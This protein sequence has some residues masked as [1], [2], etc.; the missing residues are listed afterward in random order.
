VPCSDSEYESSQY[1]WTNDDSSDYFSADEDEPVD[2]NSEVRCNQSALDTEGELSRGTNVLNA[3]GVAVQPE[4]D[5]H[6]YRMDI[7]T[8]LF[9][10]QQI[11]VF[12]DK[13]GLNGKYQVGLFDGK[14]RMYTYQLQGRFK[15]QP[16]GP[17]VFQASALDHTAQLGMIS[18]SLS[19]TWLAFARSFCPDLKLNLKAKDGRPLGAALPV[20]PSWLGIIKTPRGETPPELGTRLP[21]YEECIKQNGC[22]VGNLS[23]VDLSATY[24]IEYYT[25]NADFLDWRL[26][27]IPVSAEYDFEQFC[28]SL[29]CSRSNRLNVLFS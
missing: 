17:I 29:C 15:R 9:E 26:T 24:T 20:D 11:F 22:D 2:T 18:R 14:K 8:E 16:H 12:R 7:D 5:C 10:G 27:N 28:A 3:S 13:P 19:R 25:A 6:C 21:A 23:K 1:D 4:K